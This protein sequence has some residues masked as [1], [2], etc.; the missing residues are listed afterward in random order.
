MLDFD[1]IISGV[2]GQRET[3]EEL[4]CQIVR[5]LP[6]APD[7]EFRRIHGAGGDGG[8]EAV[9]VLADGAEQGVQAKYYT[10]AAAIDWAAIDKSVT[11]ALA[12]HPKLTTLHIAI[13]CV[14]TGQTQRKTKTGKPAVTA[15]DRWETHKAKWE[16]EATALGRSVLFDPWSAADLEALLARPEMVGLIDYW[17]GGIELSPTWLKAQADRT[18]AALEERYHPEDHVDVSVR[19]VFDGL[20]RTEAYR[21]ALLAA[22]ASVLAEA[23]PGRLPDNFPEPA[24]EK[25]TELAA[26]LA[27]FRA[28]TAVLETADWSPWPFAIWM[29]R[30]EKL[31]RL[32]FDAVELAREHRDKLSAATKTLAANGPPIPARDQD[33]PLASHVV[34]A[35]SK[36]RSAVGTLDGLLIE[37]ARD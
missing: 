22:R 1:K 32:I 8:V 5:R 7:A 28:E 25:L 9:W 26:A 13:A 31:T 24:A 33:Y 17:F 11:T 27:A 6:P 30:C 37:R 3:F 19:E 16:A 18:I 21:T 10:K 12:T 23:D 2:A 34:H 4:A 29:D 20:L 14:L 15:W 36:L 35:L